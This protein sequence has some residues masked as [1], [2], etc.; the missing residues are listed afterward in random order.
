MTKSDQEL[1]DEICQLTSDMYS[2]DYVLKQPKLWEQ[3]EPIT[4]EMYDAESQFL[5]TKYGSMFDELSAAQGKVA[6]L[7]VINEMK[8]VLEDMIHLRARFLRDEQK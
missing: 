4:Q 3:P 5:S 1:I 8:K 7:V 2:L 6:R